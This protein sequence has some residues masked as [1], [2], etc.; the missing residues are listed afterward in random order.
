VAS[1]GSNAY[2]FGLTILVKFSCLNN[3][4]KKLSILRELDLAILFQ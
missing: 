3:N 4:E 1:M 2:S